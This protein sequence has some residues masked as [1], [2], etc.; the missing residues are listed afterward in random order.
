MGGSSVKHAHFSYL[1][2]QNFKMYTFPYWKIS[3]CQKAFVSEFL[4]FM[5]T[6]KISQYL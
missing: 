6:V 2:I 4:V 3:V 1:R 5:K